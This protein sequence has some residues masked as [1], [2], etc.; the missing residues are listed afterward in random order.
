M[1]HDQELTMNRK[2]IRLK[3]L[4]KKLMKGK[5]PK[6]HADQIQFLIQIF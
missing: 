2:V 4:L 1:I 3:H 6:K 5:H